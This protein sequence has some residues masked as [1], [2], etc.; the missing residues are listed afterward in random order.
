MAGC[1]AQWQPIP[2]RRLRGHGTQHI[3]ACTL[4]TRGLDQAAKRP[5]CFEPAIGTIG[6]CRLHPLK[7]TPLQGP[8]DFVRVVPC[9]K[10]QTEAGTFKESAC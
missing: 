4:M 7:T 9:P 6:A 8:S 2:A 5:T 10:K 1:P 3:V